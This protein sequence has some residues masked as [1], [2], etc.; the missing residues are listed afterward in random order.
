LPADELVSASEERALLIA[1]AREAGALALGFFR[2]N[3]QVWTKPNDSPVTE[4]DFAVDRLLAAR[5]RTAR[6]DY[7][8]LSEETEDDPSRISRRRTFV[9]D[10]IDGTRE[11]VAGEPGW[12]VSVA[13]VEHGTPIA[14]ALFLPALDRMFSAAAGE[15]ATLN[16]APIRVGGRAALAGARLAGARRPLRSIAAAAGVAPGDIRFV[17]ALAYRV[18]LVA[19]GEVDLSLGRPGSHDWDLAAADLI[20]REAGGAVTD[21]AGGRLRFNGKDTVQP[22]VVAANAGLAAEAVSLIRAEAGRPAD[23]SGVPA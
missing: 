8:W 21:F 19:A 12:C 3:P 23:A 16:D 14:A 1:A 13:V 22:G 10:P 15:G 9:L 17:G 11:F 2:K 20:V 18:A 7:G 6:P 5:L 4:A